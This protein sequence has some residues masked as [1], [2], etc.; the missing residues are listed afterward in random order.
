MISLDGALK[1]STSL[2]SRITIKNLD[3][4]DNTAFKFTITGT[5]QDGNVIT[6][7]ISGVNGDNVSN[8]GTKVFKTV[9]EVKVDGDSGEIEVGTI[10]AFASS[11]GTKVSITSQGNETKNTFAVVGTDINGL[12][13]TET[14]F[15]ANVGGTVYTKQ[16]FKTVTSITPTLSTQGTVQAGSA[17]G[18]Q[19]MSTLEGSEDGA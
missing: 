3:N 5:D 12:S 13:Q 16:L 4:D 17:P 18:Y 15:G 14:I 11:L 10:P 19:F 6:D 8:T 9:T 1:D 7:E 2:N